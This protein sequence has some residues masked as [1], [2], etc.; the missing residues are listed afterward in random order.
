VHS[1]LAL[2]VLLAV[3]VSTVFATLLRDRFGE[4][5]RFGVMLFGGFV[6]GAIV[7]GWLMFPIPL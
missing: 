7:F 1:H 6:L 3:F 2:L 4:Q 5:L